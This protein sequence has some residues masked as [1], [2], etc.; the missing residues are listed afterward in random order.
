MAC[1]H[2]TTLYLDNAVHHHIRQLADATGRTQAG[3]IREA[4][5]RY[6][7]QPRSKQPRS[8]GMGKGPADL[9]T[10]S[11]DLLAGMGEER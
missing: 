2:K 6:V 5:E 3:V 8:V 9:S 7:T 11:E 4:I 1:M 10:C